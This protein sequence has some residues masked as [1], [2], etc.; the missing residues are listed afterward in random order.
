MNVMAQQGLIEEAIAT[1]IDSAI[2]VGMQ[3]LESFGPS[4]PSK[5]AN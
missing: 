4:G 2:E 3:L 5:P 1:H